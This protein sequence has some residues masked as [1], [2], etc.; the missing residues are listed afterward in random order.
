MKYGGGFGGGSAMKS[1][2]RKK[3]KCSAPSYG[4]SMNSASRGIAMPELMAQAAPRM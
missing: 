2:P 4:S 3:A 1:A